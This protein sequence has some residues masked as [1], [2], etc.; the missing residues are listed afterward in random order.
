MRSQSKPPFILLE[1]VVKQK[2]ELILP[3][4]VGKNLT[5]FSKTSFKKI[6]QSMVGHCF[7]NFISNNVYSKK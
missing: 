2:N 6:T 4:Y 5:V 3:F 1:N 7:G